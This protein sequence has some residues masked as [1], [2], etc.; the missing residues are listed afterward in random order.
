[1][2]AD[3]PSFGV[4]SKEADVRGVHDHV[5]GGADHFKQGLRRLAGEQSRGDLKQPPRGG[6]CELGF[7]LGFGMR[8]AHSG[9]AGHCRHER[10]IEGRKA[11]AW[12]RFNLKDTPHSIGSF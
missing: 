2:G 3:L 5:A 8:D 7:R 12:Q 6:K 4:E 9:M 11:L 1:M 10:R